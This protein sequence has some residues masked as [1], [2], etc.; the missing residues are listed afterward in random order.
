MDPASTPSSPTP[1]GPGV[2]DD[3]YETPSP[4]PEPAAARPEEVIG[5]QRA[6]SPPSSRPTATVEQGAHLHG[7]SY[8]TAT[9][10]EETRGRD[11]SV[12]STPAERRPGI[13]GWTDESPLSWCGREDR[14]DIHLSPTAHTRII[15]IERF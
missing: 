4:T 3:G 11:A 6:E 7:A 15:G 10:L 12:A 2:G 8:A 5:Q 9:A 1:G 13:G 14:L